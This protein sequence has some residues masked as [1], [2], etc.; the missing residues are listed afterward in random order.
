MQRLT[1]LLLLIAGQLS[2]A[3]ITIIGPSSPIQPGRSVRLMIGGISDAELLG[4]SATVTVPVGVSPDDVDIEPSK[5]WFNVPYVRFTGFKPGK[6]LVSVSINLWSESLTT[7]ATDAQQAKI[8]AELLK[9]LQVSVTKITGK[10]P[11]KSGQTIVEV[12]GDPPLPPP[13]PPPP[14][15][16]TSGVVWT[17]IIRTVDTL[18]PDQTETLANLREWTDQQPADKLA[19]FEFPPDAVGPDGSADVK[20]AAF[21]NRIPAGKTQPYVFVCQAGK[22]GKSVILWQGELPSKAETIIGEIQ[23][24]VKP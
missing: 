15:P 3:D 22:S 5:T 7:A 19:H 17:L 1:V 18:T 6:Y 2:A 14:V 16:V 8:D 23:K 13:P 11:A 9:E 12:A 21:V 24:A 10:Y 20:V 4:A